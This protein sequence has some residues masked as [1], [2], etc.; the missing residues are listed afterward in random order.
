MT[1]FEHITITITKC[2]TLIHT[3]VSHTVHVIHN[4]ILHVQPL[5]VLII[6][7]LVHISTGVPLLLLLLLVIAKQVAT[8][9]DQ[10][11]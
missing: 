10:N 8:R 6:I 9:N 4:L 11:N 2:L 7:H 1:S 5:L 3:S